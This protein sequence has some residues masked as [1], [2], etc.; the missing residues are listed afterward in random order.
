[1]FIMR[2]ATGYSIGGLE[3][4]PLCNA[5]S[6][7]CQARRRR[8]GVLYSF[9]HSNSVGAMHFSLALLQKL[10]SIFYTAAA[11]CRFYYD[12]YVS[13]FSF[14]IPDVDGFHWAGL[15][16]ERKEK[17]HLDRFAPFAH[18]LRS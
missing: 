13:D 7:V 3:R 6:T 16:M 1:M 18:S 4:V 14:S 8:A 2:A 12:I 5:L 9:V 11:S 10:F 17:S 15:M